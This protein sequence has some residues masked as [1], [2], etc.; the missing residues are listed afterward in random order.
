VSRDRLA[1]LK[2]PDRFESEQ[3]AFFERVRQGYLALAAAEPERFVVLDATQPLDTVT[4]QLIAAVET[5][6]PG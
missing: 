6:L 4:A 2:T 3:A 1:G 5:R